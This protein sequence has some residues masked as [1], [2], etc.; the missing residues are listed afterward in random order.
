MEKQHIKQR[1]SG[2]YRILM[3]GNV[4]AVVILINLIVRALP[5]QLTSP[6][7]STSQIY[8][9]TDTTLTFLGTLDQEVDL[10]YICEAGEEDDNV[11]RL[12]GRYEDADSFIHVQQIDPAV[13]PGYVTMYSETRVSNNSI[14]VR[15]ASRSRVVYAE[16][17]YSVGT[18]A[19]T[20]RSV[21]TAFNAERLLTSAIGYVTSTKSQVLYVLNANG[22]AAL[23]EAFLEAVKKNNIEVRTLN[24]IAQEEVPEDASALLLQ[25]PAVDYSAEETKKLLDY[26]EKGG[27]AVLLSNYTLEAMPNLDKILENYGLKR[28][29]GIILEGDSSRY[30]TYPYCVIPS[31]NYSQ[32]TANVY[33][34]VYLLMPMCQGIES[35]D[36]SRSSITMQPLLTTSGAAYSKVDVQNMTTSEKEAGDI[37]GPFTVGMAVYEDVNHD[38]TADTQLIYF[39]TGYLLD[40][41]YNESVS[42]SNAR[43]FGD[44][45]NALCGD[46]ESSAVV[47]ARNLQVQY[48]TIDSFAANFW[49]VIC[50]FGLPALVILSGVGMWMGRR[51]R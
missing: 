5:A 26:L 11:R 37:D 24:L 38:G 29:E 46:G 20:G 32:M 23:G 25:A 12:L 9:L 45:V 3:T 6:D 51:K 42:G 30:M 44:T 1:N 49:T 28:T 43:L 22:E 16:D 13:Y 4:L 40:P 21:E 7:F 39:S 41:D 10:D 18:S 35:L 47:S 19:V 50:V 17:L 34:N 15:S 36:T 8:T 14:I 2:I 27:K 48:L 33:E 31:V